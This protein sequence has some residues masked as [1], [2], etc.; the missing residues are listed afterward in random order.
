M[1]RLLI[2]A[3]L[4]IN[5]LAGAFGPQTWTD[6][7]GLTL[8]FGNLKGLSS[9][10]KERDFSM[11]GGVVVISTP[12]G[13]R[14]TSD[15]MDVHAVPDPIRPK[16]YVIQHAVSTG[17][18]VITK[19]VTGSDG[20]QTT[21]IEGSKSDYVSGQSESVV[22][23]A[24]PVRMQTLDAKQFQTMLATGNSGTAFLE[25]LGKSKLDNGLKRAMLDGSVH[26]VL[27]Q[28]DPESHKA[29]TIRTASDHMVLEN[30]ANG[31]KVTLKG[32]IHITGDDGFDGTGANTAV[33]T[34]DKNGNYSF[35]STVDK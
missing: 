2:P 23:I 3:F 35:G 19:L 1:N 22:K 29:T 32:S 7:N 31:R 14:M 30:L 21:R 15:T 10:K 6:H 28:I 5:T 8:T 27:T 4:T 18:V 13:V 12:Q 16:S 17:H 20:K 26:L 9:K 34:V 24:G 33:F 25:P 11:V